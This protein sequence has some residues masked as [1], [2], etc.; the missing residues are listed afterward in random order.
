MRSRNDILTLL[1]DLNRR[2]ADSLED[3]DLDFKQWNTRSLKDS[4]DMVVD[5]AVCMANGDGGTVVF[6]V[7]D[8]LVGRAAAILGVP[9][10]VDI[11][12]L[13][14]AVY[15]ATDPKLTPVFEELRVPEG[16]GRLLLMHIYP[17]I[18]PYT[19]TAGAAKIRIG[20]D[21]KPLTGTLRRR[22]AVETG[23]SDLSRQTVAGV[24]MADFSAAAL[25]NLRASAQLEQAPS[26]LVRLSDRDLL[27]ALALLRDG[28]PTVAAL[29]L[30]GKPEALARHLPHYAWSF[31][32]MGS[33]TAYRDRAD[34]RDPLPLALGRLTDR[35]N[36]NNP[37]STVAIGLAHFEY[38]TY[39]EVAVREALLNA[40]VHADYRLGGPIM[41]KQSS[42][43]L[44]I[45]NPGGFI[46]GI[47]SDNIL[48]HPPVPRNPLLAEALVK[49]RLINRANLGI[50]RI[51][52]ALLIEGK[53]PP[54]IEEL[55][56][57]VRVTLLAREHSAGF[58]LFVA[59]EPKAGR[60][61]GVDHLLVLQYLLH[62]PEMDTSTAARLCQ[63]SEP[64]VREVLS[65]MET[66][67]HYLERGGTGRGT[68][69][70]LAPDVFRR[71]R[72]EGSHERDRRID[73]EAAKT[74]ILSI[75]RQRAERQ[76]E[77]LSNAEIRHIAHLDRNQA[78]RLMREL[79]SET[80]EVQLVG[81]KKASRY[82][83]RPGQNA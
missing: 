19:N 76:E 42:A 30:A 59:E 74:R 75:L 61:P 80:P 81:T 41:V 49:L 48:H 47:S 11:N 56:E 15:D 79:R 2:N 71:L 10:E 34:G 35:I 22:I 21:C 54:I 83:Y 4:V 33:D 77:G 73:W 7:D 50:S 78:S 3:Q 67:W 55:G 14:K 45:S 26:D 53:E 72:E 57:C 9:P 31:F 65:Q 62:H 18:P 64:E 44:E 36:A 16:T 8:S 39:P 40:F 1:D 13:K 43:K 70:S 27:E 12:R 37:I 29:L 25:E 17:G 51:Y 60:L 5:M 82:V 6:G 58:R 69:W 32:L 68:Y 66:E 46:G 52:R 28:K 24:A 23:E 38:R 63:R 20:K